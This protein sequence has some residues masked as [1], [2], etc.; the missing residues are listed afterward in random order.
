MF[1]FITITNESEGL[2]MEVLMVAM[3]LMRLCRKVLVWNWRMFL[4]LFEIM[5]L[6]YK[7]DRFRIFFYEIFLQFI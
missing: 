2:R 1:T 6:F 3:P 7:F 4:K 5:L